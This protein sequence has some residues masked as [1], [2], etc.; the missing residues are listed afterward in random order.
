MDRQL[1]AWGETHASRRI[2]SRDPTFWPEAPVGSVARRL[3]WLDL[4]DRSSEAV[5]EWSL[6]ADVV[7]DEGFRLAVV[8]G[9]GGSSLAPS[10]FARALAPAR[11]ALELRVLDLTHPEAVGGIVAPSE[12]PTTLF[13]VSSKSG[14]TLE[15][16][17]F[18]H[19]FWAQVARTS[20]QPGR[21]FV[22]ITDPGT[23][24]AEL[25]RSRHFR[26]CF[27]APTTVGG[28]YSAL[29]AFGLVP[30]ALVGA[31]LPKILASARA[32]AGACGP[33]H[34]G[35]ENPGLLLGAQLGEFARAGRDK[36]TFVAAPPFDTFP[37][38][39]EQLLAESTGKRGRGI[40]PIAGEIDPF[41][42]DGAGDRLLVVLEPANRIDGALEAAL[43]GADALGVPAIRFSPAAPEDLG[44]EFF[45]WEFAV[46][47]AGSC[48]GIDPFDQ[49]DVE[50]AK[51]LARRAMEPAGRSQG[52]TDDGGVDGAGS[53]DTLQRAVR[54]WRDLL[55][56][57]DYVAIQAYLPGDPETLKQLDE[58]RR[59]LRRRLLRPTTLGLGPRFL[60]STGQLHKGGPPSGLFLQ[61]RDRPPVDL[62]VPEMGLTFA[63]ILRAQAMGD[64]QALREKGRRL[65]VVNVGEGRARGLQA[66]IGAVE[67]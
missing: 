34:N 1:A 30:A 21:Q 9:M 11:G 51:E 65:L 28:R 59:A 53:R 37:D 19:Y 6:F 61:I 39:A 7:R 3:G 62:R 12:L 58:L 55:R 63:G 20:P 4:P 5:G 13:L 52:P 46:A 40:I 36:V 57:D 26:R 49:P 22:A 2:W 66:L 23:P 54:A 24:L 32:M 41:G 35:P 10:V 45:R 67:A 15:P 47:A 16:N 14:T 29:S 27:E 25:A 8:L 50:L 18:F 44:G 48:L 64:A 42:S 56:P 60:H 17:A 43:T 31:D 33:E 38:W